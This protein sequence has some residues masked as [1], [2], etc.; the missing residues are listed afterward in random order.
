M[1]AVV[2]QG[3][4]TPLATAELPDP[5]PGPGELLVRVTACG[6]CGSDLHLSDALDVPGIVLGHEFAAEVVEAGPGV[7]GWSGGERIA[8]FPIVSCGSCAWCVAGSPSKCAQANQLG[9]GRPGAFAEYT[10]MAAD[11]AYRLPAALG[12]DLGALVEP[13]AVAHHALARTPRP[14][15]APVL[16][17]GA[18]PVGAAVALWARHRGARHVVVTDPVADRRDLAERVGATATIDPTT[19][20]VA[21]EFARITGAL[22]GTVI[23][24]VGIPGMIQH[25]A[26]VAAIDAH[27][28]VVGVCIP[29]DQL[30][31]FTALSKE[32]SLQ[33]VLYYSRASFGAAIEA[34]AH[35]ALDPTPLV[36]ARITLDDLPRAFDALKHPTTD[37]KVIVHP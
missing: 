21:G 33:F 11:G 9:L 26:D 3:S 29:P 22:P 20:D 7:T 35:E 37:C 2:T 25:A 30:T 27:V 14:A 16:V 15:D 18:G 28:T 17:L 10:T 4:H 36:T 8:A 13:L 23:E 1:R 12:D 19:T 5:Q 24:C 32:L 31:P 34:L 6:V